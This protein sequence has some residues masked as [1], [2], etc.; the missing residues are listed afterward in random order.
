V[1]K[2][3][4]DD[5]RQRIIE[6]LGQGKT[7]RDIAAELGR[8][9]TTISSIAKEIGHVFGQSNASRAHEARSAYG[10]ERRAATMAKFHQRADELLDAMEGSYLVF[11]FGGRDNT[12]EEHTL[13][14]PPVEAKRQLMQAARDAMRTVLDVDRHDNRNDEDVDAVSRWLRDIVG[15]G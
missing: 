13:K 5:E 9:P 12:Y 7:C 2:P 3:L 15:G 10:A 1:A 11:N 8:S 4:T 6:L 14:S